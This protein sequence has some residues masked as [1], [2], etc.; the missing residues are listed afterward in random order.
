MRHAI[1]GLSLGV[2]LLCAMPSASCVAADSVPAPAV[3]ADSPELA[4]FKKVIREKYDLKERAFAAH[5]AETI[6]T[7]FYAADAVSV[8]AGYGVYKGREQL[9]PLYEDAVKTLNVKV[10]SRHTVLNGDAGWDW[11][12]FYVTSTDPTQKPFNLVILFLWSKTD[13]QWICKGDFYVEGNFE[14]G[15]LESPA[16]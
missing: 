10:T 15:K 8:G 5:D 6:L 11:A 2:W 16:S 1:V 7:K 3:E 4:A 9:R 14:A 13:G 12:D